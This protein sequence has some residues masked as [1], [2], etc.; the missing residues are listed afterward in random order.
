VFYGGKEM[1]FGVS[2]KD[3]KMRDEEL[4]SLALK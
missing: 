2:F 4:E 3:G 1:K